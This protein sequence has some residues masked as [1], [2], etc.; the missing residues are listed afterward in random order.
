MRH[1][2]NSTFKFLPSFSCTVNGTPLYAT[3]V[4]PAA[5]VLLLNVVGLIII[6]YDVGQRPEQCSENLSSL[7]FRLR[8]AA[9]L[10][11][12]FGVAW[13]FGFLVVLNDNKAFQYLFCILATLNGFFIFLFYCIRNKNAREAW[14]GMLKKLLNADEHPD[15]SSVGSS[16]TLRTRAKTCTLDISYPASRAKYQAASQTDQV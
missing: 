4:A 8:V 10:S 7:K 1:L 6:I 15:S 13:V 11:T 3:L 16:S 9:G 5:L 2:S 12:L 14:K